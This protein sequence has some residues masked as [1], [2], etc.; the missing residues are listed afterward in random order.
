VVDYDNVAL[1]EKYA[2]P[3]FKVE[4]LVI[5]TSQVGTRM[6][7]VFGFGRRKDGAE[8]DTDGQLN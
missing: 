8:S 4:Y 5:V 7:N 6:V 3:G 1:F 2:A